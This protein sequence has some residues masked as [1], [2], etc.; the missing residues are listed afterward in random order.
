MAQLLTTKEV[1]TYLNVPKSS[2]DYWV[3]TGEF[4]YFDYGKQRHFDKMEIDR[5]LR[6]KRK[7]NGRERRLQA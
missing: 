4:A 6:T 7:V 3:R 5:W 2:I 1:M